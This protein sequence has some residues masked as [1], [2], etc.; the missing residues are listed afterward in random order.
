MTYAIGDKLAVV[1][2]T[3]NHCFILGEDVFVFRVFPALGMYDVCSPITGDCYTVLEQD[4]TKTKV[5][6]LVKDT[7]MQMMKNAV[8]LSADKLLKAN[9]TVTTLEIKTDLIACQPQFYWKQSFVSDTMDEFAQN[10]KFV[11]VDHS[12]GAV[13]YRIY[14]NKV[15]PLVQTVFGGTKRKRGR[16]RKHIGQGPAVAPAVAPA[17]MP[18]ANVVKKTR[19]TRFKTTP[20]LTAVQ[21]LGLMQNNKGHFFTA[22]F[23][24]KD[25]TRRTINCQYLKDQSQTTAGYVKVRETGKLKTG[26]NAIRQINLNTLEELKIAGKVYQL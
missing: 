16:P 17:P 9:N 12:N 3:S 20:K 19:K 13:T 23:I 1:G 2:N 5:R 21:A 15:T 24:K 8:L 6:K 22:T 18:T 25:G 26:V 7:T 11:Y 10:G 14:S 4:V